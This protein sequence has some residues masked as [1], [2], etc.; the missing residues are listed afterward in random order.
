MARVCFGPR[1]L[2]GARDWIQPSARGTRIGYDVGSLF[3]EL[4]LGLRLVPVG[5]LRPYLVAGYGR[6]ILSCL[7]VSSRLLPS[8]EAAC[9]DRGTILAV[10]TLRIV[11]FTHGYSSARIYDGF[12]THSDGLLIGSGLA[13]LNAGGIVYRAVARWAFLAIPA[14]ALLMTVQPESSFVPPIGLALTAIVSAGLIVLAM[15]SAPA[16]WFLS[17]GALRYGENLLWLVSLAHAAPLHWRAQHTVRGDC[18]FRDGNRRL[19][20]RRTF[21]SFRRETDFNA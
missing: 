8:Q 10:W 1:I 3:D 7:A 15:S 12:D 18:S 13:M 17:L 6:A 9:L 20:D 16:Q 11:M 5:A 4:E 19:R 14:A 2:H 21:L